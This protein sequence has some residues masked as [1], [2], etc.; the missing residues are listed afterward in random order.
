MNTSRLFIFFLS[1]G[2][3]LLFFSCAEDDSVLLP[4]EEL[5]TEVDT[6][7]NTTIVANFPGAALADLD[8]NLI[9][10]W[11]DLML[12]VERYATGMRPNAS[13]RALA[14]MYLAS[15]EAAVPGMRA[16]RSAQSALSGL[17]IDPQELDEPIHWGIAINTALAR[18]LNHFL[19]NTPE[20]ADNQISA[21]QNSFDELFAEDVNIETINASKDWGNYVADRVIVYA[22]SDSEAEEQI[23][24]PQPESYEP[25]TGEGFWTYS[26]EPERALFPYWGETRTFV[27]APEETTSIPP[28]AYNEQLGSDYH[29]QMMEVY[30]ANNAAMNDDEEQLWIAEF[31]SDDVEG[32]MFSPPA[33]QFSIANQLI[34]QYGLNAEQ[35]LYFYL[36]LGLSLNDAAVATW[37]Y[38]YEYMVMRPNVYI[39]EHIDPN[40]QTNLFR[41]VYWPNPSF[42]GYPSGHSCFASAAAGVFID[43][44]GDRTNFTD[45]S[46]EGRTE[47]L[48][49]PRTFE[50]FRSMARENAF[51][52]IPLG[53]HIRMDCAEGLRLGY[54]ISDAINRFDLRRRPV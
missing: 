42:P 24:D 15:Y 8:V 19:I 35:V 2:L 7:G 30:T 46:H 36:K 27:I 29:N 12:E 50:T 6:D 33:R 51:S 13:A 38:K 52:R 11:T 4:E 10:D 31:W 40:F 53:V 22:Q 32:L 9:R 20:H 5:T 16:H 43:F 48:S 25:P 18:S 47:F 14:Y 17:N 44:F 28:V 26:A 23:L 3:L 1:S 39:H 54:E 49:T 34:E 21:L 41:L 37:K 45:R